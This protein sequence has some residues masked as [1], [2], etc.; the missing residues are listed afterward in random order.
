MSDIVKIMRGALASPAHHQTL[1]GP[2]PPRRPLDLRPHFS[3][4]KY[5]VTHQKNQT[6]VLETM[7]LTETQVRAAQW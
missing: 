1:G 2:R 3:L 4:A 6:P 5:P 7:A